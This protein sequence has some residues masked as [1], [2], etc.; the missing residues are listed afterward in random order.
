M[1]TLPGVLE[2]NDRICAWAARRNYDVV[3]IDDRN[4]SVTVN[5]IREHLTPNLGDEPDPSLLLDRD[6]IVVYFC[7]HGIA[8]WPDQYWIL[9]PGPNQSRDRISANGFR[10]VLASYEPLQ[11]AFISDACRSPGALSGTGDP[12][13][14]RLEGSSRN[15]QK[16]IFYSCREGTSSFAMPA[17]ASEPGYLIFSSVLM[18]ALSA[19]DGANIDLPLAQLNRQAVTSQSL[20][21]YL[22]RNVPA[23]ALGVDRQQAPQCDPGFR[24]FNHIYEEFTGSDALDD[25]PDGDAPT[26]SDG[27]GDISLFEFD[28]DEASDFGEIAFDQ[29]GEQ[30]EHPLFGD[31]V[32]Y[33]RRQYRSNEE[34]RIARGQAE[35]FELSRSEWRAPLVS[36]V[37]QQLSEASPNNPSIAIVGSSRPNI[38][39]QDRRQARLRN[40]LNTEVSGS[41]VD[42]FTVE[43]MMHGSSETACLRYG[44]RSLSLIPFFADMHVVTSVRNFD[45]KQGLEF[46]SWIPV[47]G[48]FGDDGLLH[49]AEALKG[50]SQ[51]YLRSADAKKI[52]GQIRYAKHLDPMMGIVAAYL[53]NTV[54]DIDNIR[55]MA[56][57]YT[58]HDQPI[59]FDIAMLGGLELIRADR[60][61]SAEVPAVPKALEQDRGEP[62][63]TQVATH[64]AFGNVAGLAPVL[65]MGWPYLRESRHPFH[66]SCWR[67]ID[68]LAPSPVTTFT[69]RSAVKYIT[70]AFRGD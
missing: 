2:A 16:D 6:R 42:F 40:Q 38:L 51:G 25:D 12:V 29:D 62:N 13:L 49:S 9:S 1:P 36:L 67:F 47:N 15:P 30:S 56:Y 3:Q 55:R 43:N 27:S 52:A 44:D 23:A 66:K 46:L 65:R 68:H 33:F 70:A 34:D 19:P 21:D 4:A 24:P 22:E 10:D 11:I 54:G 17:T 69:G 28:L 57:Y 60:G 32:A 26:F 35:R 61:F 45:D 14:D 59:P 63:F 8:A 37:G 39:L 18:K 5:R 58:T 31:M 53:Y 64:R 41:R 20:S 48:D 7:G 50:L